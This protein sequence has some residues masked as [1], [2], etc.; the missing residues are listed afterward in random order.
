[1]ASMNNVLTLLLS[2]WLCAQQVTQLYP[3]T[4]TNGQAIA[5][6]GLSRW[7]MYYVNFHCEPKFECELLDM[8]P[9]ALGVVYADRDYCIRLFTMGLWWNT[10]KP[11]I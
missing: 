4:L 11:L 5:P 6:S 1:M 10:V 7:L 8:S 9:V 3:I 2:K